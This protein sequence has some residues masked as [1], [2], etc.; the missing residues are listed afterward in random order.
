MHI[1]IISHN[2]IYFENIIATYIHLHATN[3]H[4]CRKSQ[5]TK[6]KVL[7]WMDSQLPVNNKA[8][9]RPLL[10]KIT[11]PVKSPNN[12]PLLSL[13]LIFS[14]FIF[15][16]GLFLAMYILAPYNSVDSYFH[17]LFSA[18]LTVNMH[19]RLV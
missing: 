2:L 12:I 10:G 17:N 14:H 13:Y 18:L 16:T 6:T 3:L 9:N 15:Q 5:S 1:R 11:S 4:P 19:E 8:I 7:F